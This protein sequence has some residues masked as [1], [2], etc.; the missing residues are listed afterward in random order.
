MSDN[1]QESCQNKEQVQKHYQNIA[2]NFDELW[3]YSQDFIIFISEKIV[4]KLEF[5]SQ[6][7][8]LDLGCGT[9]LFT[10]EINN[11][12]GFDNP[13]IC[14]DISANMLAQLSD[15]SDYKC[16][17]M[18]AVEFSRQS[19]EYDK[20]L[21]KEMIHHLNVNEQEKLTE[22]IFARLHLGGKFLLILLPPTIEYPLF[23]AALSRYEELQPDYKYLVELFNK[24][25]F[26]T[27]VDFVEYPLSIPKNRYIMMVKNRYMSLLSSF[28][29]NEIQ[30]GVFEIEQ[31]YSD[32]DIL[33][34]NDR[35]VCIVGEK[36]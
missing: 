4:K 11:I 34:F 10:K 3:T 20:I 5:K 21:I 26:K 18:D 8:F 24:T 1:I 2:V 15:N 22:N 27:S 13:V 33:E 31:K 28:D 23:E 29:D 25:G 6:D 16:V 36:Y 12:V 9:G 30:E 19:Y 32:K 7:I 14:C 17:A 35:F